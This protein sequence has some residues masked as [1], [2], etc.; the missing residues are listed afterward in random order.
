M[1]L[2]EDRPGSFHYVVM[3]AS[4]PAT[5]VVHDPARV[6]F[7]VLARDEFTRRWDAADRWMAVVVPGENK[8]SS[9]LTSVS[10]AAVSSP[11]DCENRLATASRLA[12]A[13]DYAGA[14]RALTD[15]PAVCSAGTTLRE[16]AGVR[17]VQKRWS[18][19]SE[20]AQAAVDADRSDADAWRLLA[21]S[22]FLQDD[23]HGALR[24]WN[25]AGEPRLDTLQITGLR[26]TRA[27][28][29]VRA[30]RIEPGDRVT[31]ASVLHVER[32]L[33]Q[34]PSISRAQVE[35]V[36]RP[37]GLADL[38]A[39]VGDR[40]LVPRSVV[41]IGAVA[42]PAIFNRS[43]ELPI[44]SPTGGGERIDLSW[45][46]QQHRPRVIGEFSS[47]APWG[48]VWGLNAS[49]ERQP[50][51]APVFP[52]AER[53]GGRLWWGDWLT[54]YI[55]VQMRGGAERWVSRESALATAGT[56]VLFVT[57]AQRFR[58]RV[59]LD[60]WMGHEPFSRGHAVIDLTSSMDRRGWVVMG[61][62][63]AGLMG[64]MAQP[65]IWFGGDTSS[66]RPPLRAHRLVDDGYM[67][68]TRI[69]RTIVHASIEGQHW[70][71]TRRGSVGA[72]AF[73]D[74]VSVD[75]RIIRGRQSDADVGV[76][77][78]AGVPG[79][80]GNIRVDIARGLRDGA[81][82]VSVGFEP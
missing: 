39:R 12:G 47:P 82:R 26:R 57:P 35:Y 6:P 38:R 49:W 75:R 7:R 8:S 54:P 30:A 71:L 60:T 27:P 61:Q 16:L 29:A 2:I 24:A 36:P 55:Q 65:D 52:T 22:R 70:W 77:F 48:G 21:T 74:L 32:R 67:T 18:E 80:D 15:G 51:A 23:R 50:F 72:A 25:E 63:G 41:A 66:S 4:L 40:T 53:T 11:T 69:G 5:V 78:R 43:V 59:D 34:V 31:P 19:A 13:G 76:G 20:L 73:L 42:A 62:A 64:D 17:A 81:M 10:S 3:V 45:R 68:T 56:G 44:S 33:D 28:V 1:V 37:G 14:E 9:G 46:F 58:A 79:S